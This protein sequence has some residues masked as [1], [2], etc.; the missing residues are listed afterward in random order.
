MRRVLL[1]LLIAGV[2]LAVA[3][4]LASLPGRV[5]A[6]IGNLSFAAP[7]PVVALGLLLL[8]ALLYTTFR[9]LGVLIR[10]PRVVRER[11]AVRR[12]RTGDVAVTRTLLA[13][14]AGETGD[15]RR[16][17]SRARRLLGDTPATLLLA[18][19]AGR[20]AG[21]ADEAE[22]AFRALANSGEAALLG[23]RGLLRQAIEREDWTAAAALARQA[24]GV[25]PGAAWLRR[26]RARLA[27]RAGQWSDAL[28][29]ADAEA[30][31]AAL[32]VAAADAETEPTRALGLAK[33][34]WQE[35][36]SLVPAT[37]AYA[38]RLR[39][40]GREKRALTVIRHSWSIAP[41]PD[42]ADFALAPVSEPLERMRAAQRLTEANPDHAESRLLLARAALEAG[43]TGEARRHAE[44]AV[45]AGVKQR[46]LWLLL[47]EIEGVEGGDTEAGRIAQRDALRRAAT[48][49]PDP[50]W[51]CAACH[52]AH[53]S[54]HPSCPD[55]FTVGSL[56]WSSGELEVPR[57]LQ[58]QGQTLLIGGG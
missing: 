5:S 52:T 22:T 54:W 57:V 7:T 26:E 40:A 3:W 21:R 12:R 32:A 11:Q 50:T 49:E 1:V 51:R 14:A 34:A 45:A 39:A 31:K 28:A 18:A 46:R 43:L 10:L 44:A 37:L 27:V 33:Q 17:A 25:Q 19:E 42:L 48:A 53:A 58:D 15:A 23:L 6:D 38:T 20:I 8:F 35:D 55:C 13:L 29:L 4:V 2:V 9:L 24:E 16:E 30:P 41:H 56:R 36:P 47:A